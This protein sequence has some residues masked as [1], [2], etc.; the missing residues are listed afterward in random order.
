MGTDIHSSSLNGAMK[1]ELNVLST[2]LALLIDIAAGRT[3]EAVRQSAG[4]R[5]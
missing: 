3:V 2:F 4:R 1:D 5:E